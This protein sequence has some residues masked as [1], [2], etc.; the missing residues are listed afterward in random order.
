MGSG[1]GGHPKYDTKE[2]DT[3]ERVRSLRD[4][5]TIKLAM[6][7]AATPQIS[8]FSGSITRQ[9]I[10]LSKKKVTTEMG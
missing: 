3:R 4:H 10:V 8:S 7:R 2:R 6:E 1:V 5:V 9:G